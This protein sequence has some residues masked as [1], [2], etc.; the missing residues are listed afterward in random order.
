MRPS[1]YPD[2]PAPRIDY[3]RINREHPKLKAALTR[4][5][6]SGNPRKVA[7]ACERAVI[8]WNEVGAWPDDWARWRNALEDAWDKFTRTADG[9][10][11]DDDLFENNG[12]TAAYFHQ[13][14]VRFDI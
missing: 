13:I 9:F 12:Q 10:G 3:E 14:T 1:L 6:R 8:V 2:R 7:E 11:Y 5:Q 4:A